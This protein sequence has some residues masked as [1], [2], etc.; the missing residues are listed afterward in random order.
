MNLCPGA[1]YVPLSIAQLG[2]RARRR[3]GRGFIGH[4][5]VSESQNLRPS[6]T[7]ADWHFYVPRSGPQFFQ[8]IDLDLVAYAQL[9]GNPDL[10]SAET[11]GGVKDPDHEPWSGFQ[12]ATLAHI[13]KYL[14]DSEGIP[15]KLMQSSAAGERGF[16]WHRLGIDPWRLPGTQKWSSSRGK[17]CPGAVKISQ[18]PLVVQLAAGSGSGEGFLM[19]LTDAQQ[20]ELY[21]N[22]KAVATWARGGDPNVDNFTLLWMMLKDI[23]SMLRGGHTPESGKNN[24]H[25]IDEQDQKRAD[26]LIAE[27]TD[28]LGKGEPTPDVAG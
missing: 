28:L 27:L 7:S 2:G 6:S 12:L 20:K 19:A 1:T 10:V 13:L 21:D 24:F 14:H 4:V 9:E 8:Y 15:L 11:Q 18:A 25:W 3:K 22:A 5:A 17:L 16:G 26:D 23:T